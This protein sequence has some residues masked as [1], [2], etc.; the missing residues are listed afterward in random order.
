MAKALQGEGEVPVSADE[1]AD[2]LRVIE[3]AMESSETGRVVAWE[4]G[5]GSGDD[6]KKATM[7]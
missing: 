3:M 5:S 6:G 4:D 1:A 7:I 2:V